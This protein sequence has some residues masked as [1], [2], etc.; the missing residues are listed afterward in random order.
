[1]SMRGLAFDLRSRLLPDDIVVSYRDYYQGL[2]FYLERKITVV[3][4]QR[5]ELSFGMG[6]ED[7]SAWMIDDAQ[8]RRLWSSRQRVYLIADERFEAS[9]ASGA[10]RR[11][12]R[13]GR[14]LLLVNHPSATAAHP[15]M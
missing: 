12:A 3:A 8:F 5:S 14:R 10:A 4:P 1:M 7:V 13:S 15:A 9:L 11:I 6:V 2:P